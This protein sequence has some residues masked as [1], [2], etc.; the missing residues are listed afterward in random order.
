[1]TFENFLNIL[2]DGTAYTCLLAFLEEGFFWLF[3]FGEN[4]L[5]L[6]SKNKIGYKVSFDLIHHTLYLGYGAF[7][8]IFHFHLPL[9]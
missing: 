7:N 5:F 8:N 1:M 9:T 4:I 6:K 2:N 3:V